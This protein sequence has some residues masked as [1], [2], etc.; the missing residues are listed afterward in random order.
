MNGGVDRQWDPLLFLFNRTAILSYL[1]CHQFFDSPTIAWSCNFA[2]CCC[3]IVKVNKNKIK[4]IFNL[5][6]TERIT[7]SIV[8]ELLVGFFLFCFFCSVDYIYKSYQK[9]TSHKFMHIDVC[10][11]VCVCVWIKSCKKI[12]K[13]K[14]Q[15]KKY[16]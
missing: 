1:C 8:K 4:L 13:K 10:V 9:G 2:K 5:I 16:T 3:R 15:D 11:C 7:V 6:N 14:K 12:K